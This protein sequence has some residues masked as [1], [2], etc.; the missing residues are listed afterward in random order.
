PEVAAVRADLEDLRKLVHSLQAT[1][2]RLIEEAP[3]WEH[4]RQESAA[5]IGNFSREVSKVE[6][7]LKA[8]ARLIEQRQNAQDENAQAF[9]IE[10]Q[11]AAAGQAE[12]ARNTEQLA[13]QVVVLRN[14]LETL[15]I[16]TRRVSAIEEAAVLLAKKLE[17]QE[18]TTSKAVDQGNA[19]S[20]RLDAAEA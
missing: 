3:R 20:G 5:A 15:K 1:A 7:S 13:A 19:L 12:A 11:K 4:S 8:S 2:A 17:A 16:V 9:R 14:D 10:Q 18:Q 6:E